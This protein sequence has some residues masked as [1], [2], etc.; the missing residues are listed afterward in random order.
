MYPMKGFSS[1]YEANK[2]NG[3]YFAGCNFDD[4]YYR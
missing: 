3:V 1:M 2:I 4:G